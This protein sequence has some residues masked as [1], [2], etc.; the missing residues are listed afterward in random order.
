V[1]TSLYGIG[2]SALNAAQLGLATA[3][4]NIANANTPGYSRQRTEQANALPLQ[5][6]AGYVGQGTRVV[7]IQRVYEQ[8]A[9]NQVLQST[10]LSASYGAYSTALSQID[11][12]LADSSAGLAP[13]LQDYFSGVQNVANHPSD[14]AARTALLASG[15]ALA[16]R[17]HLLDGQLSDLRS[18][19]NAQIDASV[20][21][22][23]GY[24]RQ[25]AQLNQRILVAQGAGG[26]QPPNDLLDQRDQLV[27]R[28]NGQVSATV[29]RESDGSYN[30]F[31]GSGQPLVIASQSY[32]L[33]SVADPT[34]P[35]RKT[36]A[37]A[38][39][40]NSVLLPEASLTG[41]QLGGMLAFRNEALEPARNELGR[42]AIAVATGINNQQSLG[43]DLT[44]AL[45]SAFFTLP[46][47]QVVPNTLNTGTAQ[48]TGTI[49]GGNALTASDYR[50][51]FTGPNYTLTRLSDNVQQT[52]TPVA[53]GA[54][55]TVDG[56][57]L[58]LTAG[59]AAAGDAFLIR[60]TAQGAA[61]IDVALSDPA[62]IAAA[63]P[64]RAAA[65]AANLGSGIISAGAVNGPAPPNANLQQPV[66]LTF[67]GAGTY[68]VN[69][70]G[71]GNP[72]GVA[73]TA[74]TTITYNGWT[75]SLNGAP[76]AGDTFTIVPNTAGSGDNRNALL[77]AGL[78]TQKT[79]A[80]GTATYQSAY[81]QLVAS[82]GIQTA[83]AQNMQAAEEAALMQATQLQQSVSGVN[84]D[85]EAANLMRYQQA[86]QAAG[87]VMQIADSLFKTLLD[88]GR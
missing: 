86:Y 39:A 79:V 59:A 45:G 65:G 40:G 48:M 49:A 80:N 85:E 88:L 64:I 32:A 28:L 13:G 16:A 24:A 54:G 33:S 1:G 87:K 56:F 78:E 25:I 12:L 42:V 27:A 43:Q 29:V 53:L 38:T 23:N 8:Y 82:I 81:A 30:V 58:T 20:G 41:G 74:G 61:G 7:T 14:S 34:D 66:T 19:V 9:A 2:L 26:G 55:V 73:Y 68:D 31:V 50:L 17:F 70:T 44:G 18:G 15:Q 77:M 71:T 72:T 3:G 22:I 10:A 21:A 76:Q 83:D 6:G 36:V 60:P 63:A 47:P 37:L 46:P 69:G 75:V 62:R 35:S 4:H 5:T 52:I 11:N 67:T 51:A 57:T 84:L